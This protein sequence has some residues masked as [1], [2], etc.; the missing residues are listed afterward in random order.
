MPPGCEAAAFADDADGDI[1]NN[2]NNKISTCR[3]SQLPPRPAHGPFLS[4]PW[5]LLWPFP[6]SQP[7]IW[8]WWHLHQLSQHRLLPQLTLLKRRRG[9]MRR[10]MCAEEEERMKK[11]PHPTPPSIWRRRRR[12]MRDQF[13]HTLSSKAVRNGQNCGKIRQ[14]FWLPWI[15]RSSP[16]SARSKGGWM[17]KMVRDWEKN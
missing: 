2:I 15:R 5:H 14:N 12:K 16:G 11:H 6:K 9:R 13:L 1:S 8:L 4:D 10:L 3:A 7:P 17:T